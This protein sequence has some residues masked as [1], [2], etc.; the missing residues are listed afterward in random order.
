MCVAITI[1]T[2]QETI[3]GED[4]CHIYWSHVMDGQRHLGILMVE[5]NLLNLYLLVQVVCS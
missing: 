1:L 3:Q 2:Q 5:Y 4:I